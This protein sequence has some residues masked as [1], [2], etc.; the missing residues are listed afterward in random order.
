MGKTGGKEEEEVGETEDT[1]RRE[2]EK[3]LEKRN[4]GVWLPPLVVNKNDS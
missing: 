3:E 4:G 2:W 1:K